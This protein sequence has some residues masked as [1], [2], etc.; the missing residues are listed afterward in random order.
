[1][2]IP[3][4]YGLVVSETYRTVASRSTRMSGVQTSIK[5][6][7]THFSSA[8]N[9]DQPIISPPT[10]LSSAQSGIKYVKLLPDWK[11]RRA[12]HLGDFFPAL[13]NRSYKPCYQ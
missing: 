5:K 10:S 1:M 12:M 7:R 6:W 9:E 13:D 8:I 3:T 4:F 2:M 11:R